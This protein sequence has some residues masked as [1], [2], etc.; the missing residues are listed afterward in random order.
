MNI[1]CIGQNYVAHARELNSE[2]PQE[3]VVFMKPQTALSGFTYPSFSGDVH[4]E[5]E[6][7]VHISKEGKNI[8]LKQAKNYYDKITLGLDFTAR[9]LQE[10]LK[11]KGLPWEKCKAF[12][13]SAFVG[14]WINKEH[15]D[16]SDIA[17]QLYK[18]DVLVQRGFS[19]NMIFSIEQLIAHISEYFRLYPGDVIFTGT[20]EGVGA[21][22]PG[23]ILKGILQ[24]KKIF[25]MQI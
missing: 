22:L 1:F 18:N 24:G 13:G 7:V 2:V 14:E 21:I 19:K 6:L 25:E 15:L 12:D 20:P 9:D 17:F 8:S 10:K 11:S 16:C 23:D 4:Y 3:P 5:C